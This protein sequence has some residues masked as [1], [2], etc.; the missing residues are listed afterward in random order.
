MSDADEMSGME[1]VAE[2]REECG[3]WVFDGLVPTLM[4]TRLCTAQYSLA[5]I[6]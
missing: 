3:W 2:R 5:S 6:R 4:Y 1:K